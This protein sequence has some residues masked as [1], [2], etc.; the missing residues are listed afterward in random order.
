M[1]ELLLEKLKNL[2]GSKDWT[3]K[4]SC[5]CGGQALSSHTQEG[6]AAA[7]G[8]PFE[9]F[10]VGPKLELYTTWSSSNFCLSFGPERRLSKAAAGADFGAFPT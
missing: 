6:Q 2:G 9:A 5:V 3:L 1:L 8:L 4:E 10:G 7:P